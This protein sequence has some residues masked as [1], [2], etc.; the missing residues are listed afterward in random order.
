[1]KEELS[2]RREKV[3]NKDGA[4]GGGG[5]SSEEKKEGIELDGGKGGSRAGGGIS[6]EGRP[7]VFCAHFFSLFPAIELIFLLFLF[8][9]FQIGSFNYDNTKMHY[10]TYYLPKLPNSTDSILDFEVQDK[11]L[12]ETIEKERR[13]TFS[14][15]I[16]IFLFLCSVSISGGDQVFAPLRAVLPPPGDWQLL[17]GWVQDDHEQEGLPLHHHLLHT[18]RWVVLGSQGTN[19]CQCFFAYRPFRG[20]EL[21]LLPHPLRRYTG[22]IRDLLCV[23][24]QSS[25]FVPITRVAWRCW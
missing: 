1:M 8:Y 15:P 19:F 2:R 3:S 5:H 6:M 24:H 17:G 7:C 14:S 23:Q 4:E 25:N 12:S 22:S 10:H 18:L 21:G 11:H 9:C 16:Y 20:G 13:K